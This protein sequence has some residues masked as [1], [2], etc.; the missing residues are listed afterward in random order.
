MTERWQRELKK[1]GG[2]D[3]P[4]SRMRAQIASGPSEDPPRPEPARSPAQRITAGV[5]AF[6][7]FAAAGV[8]AWNEFRPADVTPGAAGGPAPT[9]STVPDVLKIS[10]EG[11]TT[12]IA[13]PTVALQADGLHAETVGS[14]PKGDLAAFFRPAAPTPIAAEALP[15]TVDLSAGTYDVMC[16]RIN[17]GSGNPYIG[18]KI[19]VRV[20]DQSS[21]NS[22]APLTP[23]PSAVPDLLK[24]SCDGG[25]PRMVTPTVAVQR[26]GVHIQLV[27]NPPPNTGLAFFGRLDGSM[28]LSRAADP[29]QGL[30][31]QLG[32]GTYDVKCYQMGSGVDP[33][34][35]NA[36][37]SVDVVDPNGFWVSTYLDCAFSGQIDLTPVGYLPGGSAATNIRSEVAGLLPSDTIERAGY[38]YVAGLPAYRVVRGGSTIAALTMGKDAIASVVACNDAGLG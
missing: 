8:F 12:S 3:A 2:V 34:A 4:V 38:T 9:R 32:T 30:V 18:N 17:W 25:A 16:Y 21:T 5:V 27:G 28:Y 22:A 35:I 36:A 14:W 10:C 15:I 23:T 33:A 1:L 13:D 19:E 31:L 20:V 29:T 37:D 26:D 24:V 11:G 6:A 7:V